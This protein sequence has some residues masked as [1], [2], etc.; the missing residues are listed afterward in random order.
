MRVVIALASSAH[1]ISG[2]QRHAISVA[3]CLL[4]RRE[5]NAVHLVAAPWQWQFL[6]DSAPPGDARLHLH[7]ASTGSSVLS[8]NLWYYF[9]LP[10]LAS[11]L[12]ADIVHLAYPAPLR[13][14]AFRCP[15]V[16]TLHDLYP[17]DMPHNFGFPKVFF[18]QLVL[19]QCLLAANAVACVS[20]STLSRLVSLEPALVGQKVSVVCNS[21]E[22]QARVSVCSP[23]P[24]WQGQPFLLC[25]AQ[26]RR[27]KNIV[28]ALRVFARLLNSSRLPPET[29]LVI[30]GI[31]GPETN[32][33]LRFLAASGMEDH[34]ALLSGL[35]EAEL[36]W[37]YRNCQLLL[38]PSIV[39]GFGLPVAEALLAGCRVVCSD[40][41]AFREV[42]GD[43][44]HYIPLDSVAE[45]TFANAVQA[46]V[47]EP[48]P[49]PVA[50]PQLSAP[51]IAE[52]Y[53][54]IYRSTLSS[55]AA[56]NA[57]LSAVR[58]QNSQKGPIV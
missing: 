40:I 25:V 20:A 26:H 1:Q 50:M 3:H 54:Q 33:I 9:H 31:E 52:Q 5:I 57:R 30:V 29:R 49:K 43:H 37:C 6:R 47:H 35:S 46:A 55:A 16:V 53:M 24:R 48:P 42:G 58:I 12:D 28:F 18:N 34:V 13:T 19:R 56:A 21:V 51:V 7:S 14:G 4:T 27:N 32:A 23:L 17:Y 39:E 8:R 45:Q 41:P 10:R 22:P 36:Q 15:T 44:C 11:K 2:V 38:A